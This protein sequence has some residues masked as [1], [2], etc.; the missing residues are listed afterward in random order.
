VKWIKLLLFLLVLSGVLVACDGGEENALPT[1][2]ELEAEQPAATE[3]PSNDTQEVASTPTPETINSQGR[4]TL[5]P[6]W[7]PTD[8]PTETPTATATFTLPPPPTVSEACSTF[9]IDREQS[10]SEF[11]IGESPV[12][13]WTAVEGAGAYRV[14]IVNELETPLTDDPP[15]VVDTVFTIEGEVF[16]GPGRYIWTV[17]PLDQNGIQMCTGLGDGFIIRE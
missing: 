11:Q 7:T 8:A 12:I 16:P 2:V 13:A 5:P 6:S 14:R 10:T 4:P 3:A 9:R 15:V 17:E 1:R